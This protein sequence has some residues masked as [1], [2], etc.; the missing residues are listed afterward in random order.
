MTAT[1]KDAVS[2]AS[3]EIGITQFPVTQAV[4]SSDQDIS[5]MTALLIGSRRRGDL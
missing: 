2:Q 1:V 4:G 3:M 5:Q